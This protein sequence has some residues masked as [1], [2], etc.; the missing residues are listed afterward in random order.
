MRGTSGARAAGRAPPGTRASRPGGP[1][2]IPW[3]ARGRDLRA[4]E[5]ASHRGPLDRGDGPSIRCLVSCMRL[6][7]ATGSTPGRPRPDPLDRVRAGGGIRGVGRP[8]EMRRSIL[9]QHPHFNMPCA[10]VR[11]RLILIDPPPRMRTRGSDGTAPAPGVLVSRRRGRRGERPLEDV[12]WER[13]P[14]LVLFDVRLRLPGRLPGAWASCPRGVGCV[15][16]RSPCGRGARTPG[17]PIALIL[18]GR[19]PGASDEGAGCG[20][21]GPHRGLIPRP[22]RQ[23]SGVCRGSG[24]RSGEAKWGRSALDCR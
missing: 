18:R 13:G 22:A 19:L 6:R 4:P 15:A 3:S 12:P 2:A 14:L 23:E 11:G 10:V 21:R 20:M 1:A 7:S 8:G 9:L 24:N 16:R 5:D 17:K